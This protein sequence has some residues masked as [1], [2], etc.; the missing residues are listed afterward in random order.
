MRR[1]RSRGTLG[2]SSESSSAKIGDMRSRVR[3]PLR[4]QFGHA[5]R[6][7]RKKSEFTTRAPAG[8][9]SATHVDDS[10]ATRRADAYV[11]RAVGLVEIQTVEPRALGD[12]HA[13]RGCRCRADEV[14][15]E[16]EALADGVAGAIE[17]VA[18]VLVGGGWMRPHDLPDKAADANA[19]VSSI[20]P[21]WLHD[22]VEHDGAERPHRGKCGVDAR[23]GCRR[24][25]FAGGWP[26][27][28]HVSPQLDEVAVPEV[29]ATRFVEVTALR[30]AYAGMDRSS[31]SKRRSRA[32]RWQAVAGRGCTVHVELVRPSCLANCNTPSAKQGALTHLDG[33]RRS[34]S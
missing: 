16:P 9:S 1:G 12:Q 5:H 21:K 6:A 22:R 2:K 19:Y 30:G 33:G 11:D 32:C 31:F 17:L 20:G 23:R 10:G 34:S 25:A 18:G 27:A 3:S 28:V 29:V 7:H 13:T 24:H 14:R 8:R 26:Q 4:T 15:R